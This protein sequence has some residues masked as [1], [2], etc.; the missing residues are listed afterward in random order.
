M[1]TDGV[2]E[3]V[4]DVPRFVTVKGGAYFFLPGLAARALPGRDRAASRGTPRRPSARSARRRSSAAVAA[5]AR[6]TCASAPCSGCRAG[7]ARGS[8]A[9]GCTMSTAREVELLGRVERLPG[10]PEHRRRDA[11]RKLRRPQ[12]GVVLERHQ[13][14]IRLELQPDVE[15]DVLLRQR[16]DHRV[17]EVVVGRAAWQARHARALLS[18]AWRRSTAS[19]APRRA[20]TG[21]S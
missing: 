9:T 1:P 20:G 18:G 17:P 5:T 16:R 11:R 3:R 14:R 6:S 13:E 7:G 8:S 21:R 2:R 4:T 19:P 12:D 10:D 15:L